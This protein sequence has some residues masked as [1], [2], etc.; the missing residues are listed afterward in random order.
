MYQKSKITGKFLLMFKNRVVSP[1]GISQSCFR[2]GLLLYL[3]ILD[4]P[5]ADTP[6]PPPSQPSLNQGVLSSM[7]RA[8][9]PTSL[10][11]NTCRGRCKIPSLGHMPFQPAGSLHNMLYP[12]LEQMP[13]RGGK[14]AIGDHLA[15]KIGQ[16]PPI[17]PDHGQFRPP[18]RARALIG[19]IN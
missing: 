10:S 16:K 7:A 11:N 9:A 12:S 2:G 19:A 17:A 18:E 3:V 8:H 15:P 4:A 5:S 14:T 6:L 13:R 1:T